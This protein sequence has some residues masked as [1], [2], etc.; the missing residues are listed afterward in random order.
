MEKTEKKLVL[1]SLNSSSKI[2]EIDLFGSESSSAVLSIV[3]DGKF[4]YKSSVQVFFDDGSNGTEKYPMF[5]LDDNVVVFSVPKEGSTGENDMEEYT[6]KSVS[7]IYNDTEYELIAAKAD[8]DTI[9][10]QYL[11]LY[12]DSSDTS[13]FSSKDMYIIRSI[14]DTL[15]KSG[16]LVKGFTVYIN[17]EEQEYVLKNSTVWDNMLKANFGVEPQENDVVRFDI[18]ANGEISKMALLSDEG[19]YDDW[20]Y[21]DTGYLLKKEKNMAYIS[22]SRPTQNGSVDSNTVLVPLNQFKITILDMDTN[23]VYEGSVG[24]LVSYEEDPQYYSKVLFTMS[25]EN[26][27]QLICINGEE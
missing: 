17:G 25:Y 8:D 23:E 7:S 24:D 22:L 3:A 2:N 27:M 13:S 16:E 10:A 12:E 14:S 15:N 11:V 6:V 21:A 4:T 9:Y 18:D 19:E 5:P 20:F 26:P 1:Y